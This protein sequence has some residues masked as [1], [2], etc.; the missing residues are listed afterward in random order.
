MLVR[1]ARNNQSNGCRNQFDRNR[2]MTAAPKMN[3]RSAQ[4]PTGRSNKSSSVSRN[5][6]SIASGPARRM[7]KARD[8]SVDLNEKSL[9]FQQLTA[10]G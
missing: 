6:R 4:L 10:G 3:G 2:A 5:A 8:D 9:F 7:L 1:V